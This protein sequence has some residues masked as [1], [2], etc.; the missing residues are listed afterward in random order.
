MN[1]YITIFFFLLFTIISCYSFKG[2]S[3]SPDINTFNI[4]NF[5]LSSSAIGAPGDLGIRFTESLRA[6]IRNESRLKYVEQ[7]PDIEIS[8]NIAGFNIRPE[9]PQ[10]GNTVALNKFEIVISVNFINNKD[11][12][13]SWKQSFSF[14]RTFGS[15][16]D[17]QSVQ[18]GLTNEIFRQINEDIFNKAFTTW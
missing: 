3:I 4:E 17:F 14:F 2:I 1:K 6:K 7:N 15:D 8:G 11:E 18:E 10:A 9:A 12:S 16:Q 5:Q 13:Q